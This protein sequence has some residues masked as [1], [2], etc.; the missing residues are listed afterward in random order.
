MALAYT[1]RPIDFAWLTCPSTRQ[2]GWWVEW[3]NLRCKR[4][5][6][7]SVTVRVKLHHILFFFS[8]LS[9]SLVS[10]EFMPACYFVLPVRSKCVRHVL[11]LLPP[12]E[13][14]MILF[15]SRTLN[16][17]FTFSLSLRS[18]FLNGCSVWCTVRREEEE[19]KVSLFF[20]Y[21]PLGT[22]F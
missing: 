4:H 5:Q 7:S 16:F 21:C 12:H 20:F 15:L 3:V 8:S 1:R 6:A 2:S 17:T 19:E 18:L 10:C 14:L 9:V 13:K 11:T 22:I